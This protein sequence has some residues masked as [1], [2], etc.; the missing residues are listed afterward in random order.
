MLQSVVHIVNRQSAKT[1]QVTRPV[2]AFI[3]SCLWFNILVHEVHVQGVDNDV[4]DAF[5]IS[6]WQI[7][8]THPAGQQRSMGNVPTTLGS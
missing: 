7:L 6:R 1:A 3:E 5:S 8:G 4:A 2:R